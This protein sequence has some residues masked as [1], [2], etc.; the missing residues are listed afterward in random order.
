MV[1]GFDHILDRRDLAHMLEKL[2]H[3]L[4][5]VLQKQELLQ[6]IDH[7][8]M[9][10]KGLSHKRPSVVVWIGTVWTSSES[11]S[12]INLTV[13]PL[14]RP[15]SWWVERPP[16]SSAV[17]AAPPG[18]VSV[19]P[20]CGWLGPEGSFRRSNWIVL[21]WGTKELFGTQVGGRWDSNSLCRKKGLILGITCFWS[22]GERIY[23][24]ATYNRM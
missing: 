4:F 24:G 9:S 16:D 5:T 14:R 12:N 2:E 11:L 6:G 10:C 23:A 3:E 13:S 8:P 1:H 22:P 19:L 20:W 17:A 18:F 7:S 15:L 21:F